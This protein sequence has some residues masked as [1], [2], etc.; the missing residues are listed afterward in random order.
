MRRFL[1]NVLP[2]EIVDRYKDY[3]NKHSEAV[4]TKWEQAGKPVPPPHAIKQRTIRNYQKLSGYQVLVETG[5]YK[6]DMVFAMREIFK[7]IYSIELSE[8]LHKKA[9]KR[10]RKYSHIDLLQ[11]NSGLVISNVLKEL[12]QPAIF[13][14]DGHYSGGITASA[15]KHSPVIDELET[16]IANNSLQH[17]ILIDDARAFTGTEGYLTIDEVREMTSSKFPGYHFSVEDDIIRMVPTKFL[18]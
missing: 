10:F 9:T 2:Q 5:T 13:W 15:E 6:G 16:L 12:T 8:T 4:I 11:G 18:K 14:L 7:K 17:I 3:R 1:E